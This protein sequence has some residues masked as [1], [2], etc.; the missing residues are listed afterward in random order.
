MFIG[1]EV[2]NR[3][4]PSRKE[5]FRKSLS[6]ALCRMLKDFMY[7]YKLRLENEFLYL[8]VK[9]ESLFVYEDNLTNSTGDSSEVQQGDDGKCVPRA[10]R[11]LL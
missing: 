8:R 6:D 4:L 2:Q 7:F 3:T 5:E 10:E 9:E 11:I 1:L